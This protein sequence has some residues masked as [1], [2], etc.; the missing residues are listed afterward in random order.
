MVPLAVWPSPKVQVVLATVLFGLVASP[1]KVRLVPTGEVMSQLGATMWTLGLPVTSNVLPQPRTSTAVLKVAELAAR[2]LIDLDDRGITSAVV[3]RDVPVGLDPAFGRLA[4]V[5]ARIC[6][7]VLGKDTQLKLVESSFY[8]SLK[9][10][11]KWLLSPVTA[12]L[13]ADYDTSLDHASTRAFLADMGVDYVDR[14]TDDSKA[15]TRATT[16]ISA[17]TTPFFMVLPL[18]ELT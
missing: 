12:G 10:Y 18:I 8:G 7:C 14:P 2:Q 17:G 3:N 4:N 16:D 11:A 1:W 15:Y 9:P 13:S 5:L 6:R